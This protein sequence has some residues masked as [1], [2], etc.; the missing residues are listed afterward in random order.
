MV[1]ESNTDVPSEVAKRSWADPMQLFH[2]ALTNHLESLDDP[3]AI[4]SSAC[5][6]LRDR[7][8]VDRVVFV[9]VLGGSRVATLSVEPSA[10]DPVIRTSALSV[11]SPDRLSEFRAGRSVVVNDVATGDGAPGATEEQHRKLGVQ[12]YVAVPIVEDGLWMATMGVH[13]SAPRAWTE[14]EVALVGEAGRQAWIALTRARHP[15]SDQ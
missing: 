7:L 5:R 10:G 2:S 9:R 15:T 13:Q 8:V 12:A 1:D 14:E 11:F 4:Q 3:V 6:L